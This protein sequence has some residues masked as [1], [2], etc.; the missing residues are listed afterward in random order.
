MNS[1]K[2]NITQVINEMALATKKCGRATD[3]VQ[4]LA[5]SKT[6]PVAAIEQAIDAGLFA[7]GENYVQEGVDKVNY[8]A[9]HP[10]AK[11]LVWH[12][13]DQSSPIKR[14]QLPSILIGFIR[15]IALKLPL[16]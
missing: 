12:F 14:A 1:I 13:I 3:S 4:L 6:K 7:F 16:A 5:V 2:Q 8:F 9:N 10:A 11:Q 15:L